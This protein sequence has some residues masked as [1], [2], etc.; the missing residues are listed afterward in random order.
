MSPSQF[1]TVLKARWLSALLALLLCACAAIAITMAMPNKYTA[2]A[3]V[4]VD[5]KAS[6]PIGAVS[7]GGGS[8]ATQIDIVQSE[9]VARR[10]I[11][12][13]RLAD[14]AALREQWLG[15]TEG[16]GDFIS[17]LS[18]AL[19]SKLDVKPSLQSNV[20]TVSYVSPDPVF[21][22]AVVNAFTR[23]YIDTTL[24]L[25]V[26]PARQ[27][28]SFFDDRT[29]QMRD[30]L[31]A[32]QKKLSAYQQKYGI[33]AT[34]E[35]LDV[36]NSRLAE[37]S[38][39]L[40]ALQA[41]AT[42]SGT[43]EG[44]VGRSGDRMQEVFNNPIV[45]SIAADVTRLEARLSELTNRLGDSNPQVQDLRAT[46]AQQRNKLAS[47][48]RRVT[49]SLGVA[50]TINQSR[51]AQLRNA[52]EEQREKVLRLRGARD[53]AAVLLR[54]VENA[55]RSY[56]TVLARVTQT[57]LES[58]NTLTNVSVLKEASPPAS[59]SSP[60]VNLNIAVGIFFGVLCAV[61]TAL[62]RELFDHRLRSEEDVLDGLKQP[63]LGIMPVPTSQNAKGR[64]RV[65]QLKAR[66]LGGLPRPAAL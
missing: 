53:Q 36:E 15:S 62:L 66:V 59:P 45:A 40:V 23:G 47:E 12:S 4:L 28:N 3:S 42:D 18:D 24:E 26:E 63:L 10:A 50:N 21:S 20:L 56:D 7:T 6:D 55:Q 9:R 58:Q 13:M 17:W 46:L 22:A 19:L 57:S 51:V 60:R 5:F 33:V 8:I 37:L 16:R 29:K 30:A 35:R 49:N 44:Q 27:Y 54:D 34:D 41:L 31:E 64:S 48:T 43:R 32:A 61:G 25:K 2:T 14:S 11:E 65:R 38:S 39:Q 1:L 52:L